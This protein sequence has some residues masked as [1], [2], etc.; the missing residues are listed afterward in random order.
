MILSKLPSKFMHT[1]TLFSHLNNETI[2]KNPEKPKDD[3]HGSDG[4]KELR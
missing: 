2:V 1:S 3:I 4:R